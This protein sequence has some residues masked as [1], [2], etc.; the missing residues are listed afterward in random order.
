MSVPLLVLLVMLTQAAAPASGNAGIDLLESA[1]LGQADRV[2]DLLARGASVHAVDRRGFTPLMWACASGNLAVANLLLGNGASVDARARDGLTPLM[3]ASA[4][5]FIDLTRALILR[6]SDVNAAR[7]GVT[8]RQLAAARG[9]ANVAVLLEEAEGFGGKLLRAAAE[10]ND[11]G[12]R[13][14]LASGAP[15]NVTDERGLNALMMAA[16]NGSLGMMQALL[17]R[18]AD[19][20]ARDTAGQGVFEWAEQSSLTSKYVVA[21]LV[22]HGLSR[23]RVRLAGSAESPQVRAS[24]ET[25][26]GLLS[27]IPPASPALRTAQRRAAAALQQL[28]MLSSNWPADSPEDYRDNLSEDVKTLEAAIAAGNVDALVATT[29]AVADDLE[30]KLEHCNRS[31][32]KLGGSVTVRVR[33]VKGGDE[34]ASWQVFYMPRVLEA[35]PNASPD[36]FP[37]LSSPTEDALVPGRYVMWARDPLSARVGERTVVKVGEGKKELALDLPVPAAPT[38]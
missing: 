35:A 28:Q 29:Q 3:L 23:E 11:T 15:V 27:R 36:V 24:L 14:L 21:F 5:G 20:T 32:G 18:G 16:R 38:R 7:N 6:G 19:A 33:T 22:D 34:I 30:I 1:K 12:V 10:G 37:Q 8:A 13:Q 26:A 9:H 17:S 25:L 31:G 2:K 4:N